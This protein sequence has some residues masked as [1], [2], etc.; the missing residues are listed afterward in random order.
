MIV[1]R[2]KN[3]LGEDIKQKIALF[4]DVEEKE[5]I[6][7]PNLDTIYRAPMTFDDQKVDQIIAESLDLPE[8]KTA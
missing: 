6:S 1:G 7:D 5:V 2:S 4:C 3:E 8:R